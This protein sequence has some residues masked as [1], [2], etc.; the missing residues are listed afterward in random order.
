METMNETNLPIL[1]EDDDPTDEQ[2]TLAFKRSC[3]EF[4]DCVADYESDAF[5]EEFSDQLNR[6]LN[7][8]ALQT[9]MEKN[10]ITASVREDGEIGY[11]LT[12]AGKQVEEALRV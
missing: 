4:G 12:P 2:L 9:L 6:V 10:L 11:M 3:R 1:I 8:A 5:T 7:D